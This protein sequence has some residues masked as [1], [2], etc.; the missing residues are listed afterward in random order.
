MLPNDSDGPNRRR[1]LA[2]ARAPHRNYADWDSHRH[3]EQDLFKQLRAARADGS[4]DRRLLRFTT[5][6]LPVIDDLGLRPLRETE[7]A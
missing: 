4:H 7:P 5:P 3:A 6:E 1:I 2:A